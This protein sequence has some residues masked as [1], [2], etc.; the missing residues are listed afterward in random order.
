MALQSNG[1]IVVAGY[2]S[3][4]YFQM[5]GVAR[6]NTNGSLDTSLNGTGTVAPI[7]GA[8][9][10]RGYSVAVQSNGKIVIAGASGNPYPTYDDFALVRCNVN[11]SLDTSFGSG[12]GR[13]DTPIGGGTTSDVG[14]SVALQGDGKI[15]DVASMRPEINA[16]NANANATAKP[17]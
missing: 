17:T 15:V 9:Y 16:A 14:Y 13:V 11:G 1:Q 5:F 8:F 12:T 6:Y 7:G 10:A 2:A 3:P 4:T